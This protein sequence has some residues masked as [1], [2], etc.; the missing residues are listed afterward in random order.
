MPRDPSRPPE[1]PALYARISQ[2]R[3]GLSVGVADQVAQCKAHA[4]SLGWPEPVVYSDNDISA[5]QHGVRRP[6]FEQLLQDIEDRRVDGLVCRHLDRLLRR[7]LDIERVL[8]SIETHHMPVPVVFVMAG[9][10]DLTTASGR[11]LARLLAAVAANESEVKSERLQSARR[12]DAHAGLA[13]GPLGYGFDE[14]RQVV[15]EEAEIVR[16]VARRVLNGDSLYG[17]AAD[18]NRRGVPT[19]G[20]GR[21]DAMRV[22][23]AMERNDRPEL[24]NVI[25]AAQSVAPQQPRIFAG[26]LRSAG[27]RATADW[28]RKHALAE[29]LGASDHGLDAPALARLLNETGVPA[30]RSYWRPANVR[31]MVRRGALCGWRE[32]SPGKRGGYGAMVAEGDWPAILSKDTVERIREVTDRPAARGHG[33]APK[34]LLSTVLK[35]GRC[36]SSL[37]GSPE[38]NG[39]RYACSKQPGRSRTCGGLTIAGPQTDQIVSLAVVDALADARV[40]SGAR[41]SNEGS[42]VAQ[43]QEQLEEITR[44]RKHYGTEFAEGRLHQDEWDAMRQVWA[45]RQRDAERV[46]TAW[47][48]RSTSLLENVPKGRQDIQNWWDEAS[49]PARREV[50]LLLIERIEIAPVGKGARRF[51][52]SRIGDPVWRF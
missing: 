51:D 34:Y 31:A 8:D 23:R 13:H 9:E 30:D 37:G 32:F 43:A 17:I 19:P 7:V 40:R 38:S 27:G 42:G 47:S 1:R 26:L 4:A 2:D 11:L 44:L 15:A 25:A 16:E 10:I 21:W 6:G 28:L 29:H 35:C 20:A 41:R 14:E 46:L 36:G 49:L 3:T 12:R 39:W 48:P 18:L 5:H 52:P 50:V 33:R 24:M 22:R 45:R